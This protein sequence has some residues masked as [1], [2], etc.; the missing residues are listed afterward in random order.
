MLSRRKE[1]IIKYF[2]SR[3]GKDPL[4]FSDAQQIRDRLPQIAILYSEF[5]NEETQKDFWLDDITWADLEM[6]E[7]FLRIDHLQDK[8]EPFYFESH[9]ESDNV[10]FDYTIH[11][12][13]GGE[14]NAL[15]LLQAFGFPGEI[16]QQA[17]SG[18][19]KE[20]QG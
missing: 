9:I 14:T 5:G 13:R 7:V 6:D 16:V 15:A 1:R 19:N 11:K 20:T 4:Q 3:F 8:F 18:S 10:V 12:G 17:L 2:K